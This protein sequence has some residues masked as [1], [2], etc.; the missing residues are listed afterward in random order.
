VDKLR[1]SHCE[2]ESGGKVRFVFNDPKQL[3]DEL[4]L[5]FELGAQLPVTAVFASQKFL[6]RK[7]SETLNNRKIGENLVHDC[8]S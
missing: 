8:H 4:E 3:G 6:R 7:I 5:A 1:L 2:S